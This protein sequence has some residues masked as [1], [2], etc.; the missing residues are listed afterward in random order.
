MKVEAELRDFFQAPFDF[1]ETT[2]K[3]FHRIRDHRPYPQIIHIR[4][5]KQARIGKSYWRPGENSPSPLQPPL[6]E[7]S[8][9]QILLP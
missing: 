6:T 4:M 5:P 7:P 2:I 1:Q 9:T 3:E 8:G